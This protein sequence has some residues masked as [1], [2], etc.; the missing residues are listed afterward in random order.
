MK[1]LIELKHIGPK[2][3]VRLLI[4]ELCSRLEDKLRYA[5][6]EAVSVHLVFEENGTHKL[7]RAS[8]TCHVPHYV[9]A[10]HEEGRDPGAALRNAFEEIEHQLEKHRPLRQREVMQ[11][12]APK[13][14][15]AAPAIE[16]TEE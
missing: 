12:H 11:K 6:A 13:R 3:H 16:A 4:N 10:A 5:D 9:A 8:V 1:R 7:Y 2:E 15:E 14:R